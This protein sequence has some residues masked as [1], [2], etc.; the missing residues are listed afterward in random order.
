[1]L[2][3]SSR[4]LNHSIT[5]SLKSLQEY[6]QA[7]LF[8]FTAKIPSC[9]DLFEKPLPP[10]IHQF[11][12]SRR[13][14]R[15]FSGSLKCLGNWTPYSPKAQEAS[16]LRHQLVA[17]THSPQPIS[18]YVTS[19]AIDKPQDWKTLSTHSRAARIKA[20]QKEEFTV[21]EFRI[22]LLA[23]SGKHGTATHQV[24]PHL[25]NPECVHF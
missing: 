7:S 10:I 2:T 8:N 24:Q 14:D 3:R 18:P 21:V 11:P 20:T 16:P 12:S 6:L 23:R 22:S 1:M 9:C 19:L 17:G 15:S 4:P 5:Q 13:A 25:F